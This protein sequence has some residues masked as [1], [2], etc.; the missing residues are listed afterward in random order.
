MMAVRM[1]SMT[2]STVKYVSMLSSTFN[3]RVFRGLT[4]ICMKRLSASVQ[5]I[6]SDLTKCPPD[7]TIMLRK[8]RK[9][10]RYAR[11]NSYH[12][13]SPRT[14]KVATSQKGFLPKGTFVVPAQVG[15]PSS[16]SSARCF[17]ARVFR[18][19]TLICMKR[20]SASV[21]QM[22]SDL[23]KCPPDPTIML[24]KRRKKLRYA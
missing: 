24:R 5:Q 8:R 18:G 20:L 10:L 6:K 1:L 17:N 21:Q 12:T 4:F 14:S 2:R 9:K 13:Q 16:L 19:L 23:T 15:L 11:N 7:P 22:K 3:A